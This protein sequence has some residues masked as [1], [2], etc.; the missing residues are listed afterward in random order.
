MSS[1]G[2]SSRLNSLEH[3]INDQQITVWSRVLHVK[4]YIGIALVIWILLFTYPPSFLL[5]VKVKKKPQ[6]IQWIRWIGVWILLTA[7]VCSIY[8]MYMSKFMNI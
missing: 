5:T 1:V 3:E 4:Y 7:I 6:R 8:Y 2:Y